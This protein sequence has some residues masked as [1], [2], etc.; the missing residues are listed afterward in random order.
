MTDGRALLSKIDHELLETE[1]LMNEEMAQEK[2][3]KKIRE[4]NLQTVKWG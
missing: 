4:S 1:Q 2:K 3:E